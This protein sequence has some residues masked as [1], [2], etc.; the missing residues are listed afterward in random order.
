V[1]FIEGDDVYPG[2][3]EPAQKT[4]KK[5]G[6]DFQQPVRLEPVG[7]RRT[8]MMQRQDGAH[9]PYQGTE[10]M[11]HPGE[12]SGL[13]STADDGFLQVRQTPGRQRQI[14]LLFRHFVERSLQSCGQLEHSTD[15]RAAFLIQKL[16]DDLW[17]G[18]QCQ[19]HEFYPAFDILGDII[20]QSCPTG[21]T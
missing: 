5:I 7:A 17:A 10:P 14:K 21:L 16:F 8:H 3:G 6:C 19:A 12:I 18:S 4:L 11:V 2:T 15:L 9:T 13:K 20:N 1:H